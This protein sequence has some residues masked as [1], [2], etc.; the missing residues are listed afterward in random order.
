MR[1]QHVNPEEGYQAFLDLGAR[2]MVPMHWGCFDLTDEPA[3]L[4]PR[5][6][7]KILAARP[8]R[9]RV[10]TMAVGERWGGIGDA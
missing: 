6:L 8:D 3:D 1:A 5:V 9:D 2:T 10:H 7:E 4:A